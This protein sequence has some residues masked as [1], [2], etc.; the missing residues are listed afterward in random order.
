MITIK[1]N[2]LYQKVVEIPYY[3]P[4]VKEMYFWYSGTNAGIDPCN[5]YSIVHNPPV[6]R[7]RYEKVV[8]P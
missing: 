6:T 3:K 5:P 1:S 7:T 8:Q 4:D 2:Q